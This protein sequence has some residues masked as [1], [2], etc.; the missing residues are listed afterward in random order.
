M[1]DKLIL[2]KEYKLFINR[3]EKLVI[4]LNNS[5]KDIKTRIIN[6]MY[7]ILEDIYYTN[8]LEINKRKNYQRKIIVKIKMLDYYFYKLYKD[9]IILE[10][11]YN[12][13]NNN[14]LTILKLVLGW[15]K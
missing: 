9:N 8:L 5:Y 10:I 15:M 13:I 1:E 7:N 14:L 4:N 6:T 12:K 11:N 3:Y 2:L